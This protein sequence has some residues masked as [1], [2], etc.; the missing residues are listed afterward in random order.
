VLRIPGPGPSGI[1]R[2]SEDAN[3]AVKVITRALAER[4]AAGEEDFQETG[5]GF[6]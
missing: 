2:K 4:R 1:T 3:M 5:D 6:N